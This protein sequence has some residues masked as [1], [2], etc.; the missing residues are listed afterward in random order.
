M[1][2]CKEYI[3]ISLIGTMNPPLSCEQAGSLRRQIRVFV[4]VKVRVR[5]RVRVR[6]GVR[7]RVRIGDLIRPNGKAKYA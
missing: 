6:V 4:T 5:V 1:I 7:V 3:I 2:M